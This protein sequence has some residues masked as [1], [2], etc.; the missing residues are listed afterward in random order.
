MAS[1]HLWYV[2]LPSGAVHRLTL[3]ELDI[4]FRARQIDTRTMVVPETAIPWTALGDLARSDRVDEP[5]GHVAK[6]SDRPVSMDLDEL[7]PRAAGR[8]GPWLAALSVVALLAGV[9]AG[10]G[11][12]RPFSA[13]SSG[14]G[15]AIG[16]EAMGLVGRWKG[17]AAGL[18]GAHA[19]ENPVAG[20]PATGAPVDAEA[21]A[22]ADAASVTSLQVLDPVTVV[23]AHGGAPGGDPPQRGPTTRHGGRTTGRK[24]QSVGPSPNI[25]SG[26]KTDEVSGF[27]T[28]GSKYDP[29]NSGI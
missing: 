26:V 16:R 12:R 3:D 20:R 17:W 8:W 28:G 9:A 7:R 2:R 10:V 21:H 27:T 15:R 5:I 4:A 6:R 18:R 22:A 14:L 25:K 1:G 24:P 13:Q 19:S 23:A 11:L 29:L